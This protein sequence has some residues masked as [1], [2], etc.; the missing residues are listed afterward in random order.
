MA[1]SER[2]G[3]TRVASRKITTADKA[4]V[5]QNEG[6]P[7]STIARGAPETRS[8]RASGSEAARRRYEPRRA[9]VKVSRLRVRRDGRELVVVDGG[10]ETAARPRSA[11]DDGGSRGGRPRDR[12]ELGTRD[13]G[14]RGRR[15]DGRRRREKAVS[16]CLH[17]S[18]M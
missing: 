6:M 7:H 14:G 13:G 11:G 15:D 17:D 5:L 16:A 9:I 4:I 18:A 10:A 2:H 8:L 1:L 12:Q 3:E